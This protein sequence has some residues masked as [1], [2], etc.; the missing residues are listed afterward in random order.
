MGTTNTRASGAGDAAADA[1]I[2]RLAPLGLTAKKMF[3]GHS[4]FSE[5]AMFGMVTSAGDLAFKADDATKTRYEAA[6]SERKG[7]M[8][9]WRVPDAVLAD[10]AELLAWGREA[11]G[12]A[13]AAKK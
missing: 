7:R 2:E 10:E 8:P 11:V 13:H 4:L 1:F 9:Y 6:G 5:G 3:G 12:V